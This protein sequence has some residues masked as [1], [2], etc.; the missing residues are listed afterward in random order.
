[1]RAE[2]DLLAHGDPIRSFFQAHQRQ[3]NNVLE[4]TE[5]IAAS[6]YLYNIE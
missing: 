3:H 5:V 1:M 6:H 2:F 4:F